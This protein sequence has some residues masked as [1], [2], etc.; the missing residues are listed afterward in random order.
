V[1]PITLSVVTNGFKS[2]VN[3]MN[4]A[5]F[6]SAYSPV[7]TEGRDIG[8]AVIDRHGRLVAQGDWDLAVFVALLEFSLE[9]VL[10]RFEGDIA[11]G[12]VFI[13]NDPFVGGT[14]FNDVGV[15]R[16]VFDGDELMAFVAVCGHWA[17]VGGQ[18]PGSFVANAREHFQEGLRMP[19]MKLYIAGEP[20]RAVFD[21]IAANMRI[22]SERLGD[23]RAQVGSTGVGEQ[24]L[25]ELADKYGWDQ[26]TGAMDEAIAH[27]ERLLR[28]E[29]SK[30]P[31]GRFKGED[32]VDME[33]LDRPV[34][35]K[36]AL[37]LTVDGDSMHFD[38]TG[39]DPESLSASNSTYS[40]TASAVYVT[41]KSLFP[42]I[43]MNHGVFEPIRITAPERTVVNA[44]PPRA[45]SSMAATVYEK[46]I[47][48]ALMALS[49]ALPEQAVGTPY[50]LINLTI[51]GRYHDSDFVAYLFS[52][53]GFGG[54]ATKD[55]PPGL[56]SL[57][58]GGAKITPVEVMERRYPIEFD[59]WALWPDSAGPGRHRG[60]VG[61]RKTFRIV[62]TEARLSCLGDREHYPP[63]GVL[64]GEP[65]AKHGLLRNIGTPSE[66]NL[67]LKVVGRQLD[68]GDSV[69][70]LAGGG[71]GYGDPL[72][73]D[74]ALVAED[75]IQGYVTVGH[76][77]ERYGVVVDESGEIA[78]EKT[79]RLRA[80]MRNG[81]AQ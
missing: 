5:L 40:S 73:R 17:D 78:T 16:P 58:G 61:S 64:G 36:I 1:D 32:H 39:S 43:P 76:A 51:G 30:V 31:D 69:T 81:R 67:T 68:A 33:S 75:V 15:V 62:D 53:G 66:E 13:M 18:E 54:R 24:R 11:P 26:V 21:I 25:V 20:N 70:I 72:D 29:I 35:K 22:S 48:A 79:E 71:G 44:L 55:G 80:S 10:E 19:P 38:F 27:A 9:G 65:G 56:V 74:P 57:Y 3:E 2:I 45:I 41:V 46:V 6:R 50:N 14:H 47:G 34:P 28:S 63:A 60:G 49:E 77:A 23:V 52:E 8:G 42:E 7:I 37:E 12:D 59:E 4:L